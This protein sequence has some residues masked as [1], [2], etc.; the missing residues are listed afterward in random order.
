MQTMGTPTD[1]PKV[2]QALQEQ[3]EVAVQTTLMEMPD[4]LPQLKI[5]RMSDKLLIVRN[6]RDIGMGLMQLRERTEP[7]QPVS[8]LVMS[9]I[10]GQLR[11]SPDFYKIFATNSYDELMAKIE[12]FK[13]TGAVAQDYT[14]LLQPEVQEI[15]RALL[16]AVAQ[17][18]Q[19][20]GM[21]E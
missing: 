4:A 10:I 15:C 13:D 12:P 14:Y 9:G 8:P 21:P 16:N 19:T 2:I 6:I 17:D 20:Q 18:S 11:S 3:V 7:G 5:Q 1:D